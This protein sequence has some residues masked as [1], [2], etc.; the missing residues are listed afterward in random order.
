MAPSDPIDRQPSPNHKVIGFGRRVGG[1]VGYGGVWEGVGGGMEG[2]GGVW[3]GRVGM[4]REDM[5][6]YGGG[7]GGEGGVW[8][9]YGV[10][11]IWEGMKGGMGGVWGVMGRPWFRVL[12]KGAGSVSGLLGVRD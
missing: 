11:E 4:G 9:R 10:W 8:G 2:Y 7:M 5:V 12:G 6:E 1:M 3:V